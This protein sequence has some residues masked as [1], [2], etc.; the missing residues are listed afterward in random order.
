M[1]LFARSEYIFSP[2]VTC[3]EAEGEQSKNTSI[4]EWKRCDCEN[5]T[6]EK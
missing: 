3:K 6:M 1:F 4:A 5:K 2:G